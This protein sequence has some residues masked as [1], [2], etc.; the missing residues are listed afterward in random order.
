MTS[1]LDMLDRVVSSVEMATTRMYGERCGVAHALDLIGQRW[2]LLI[3]RELLLGPRRFTDLR[4]S[5][6]QASPD[7]LSRRLH[8]LEQTGVL[9]RHRLPPPAA[10]TVYEL[11]EWG[12]ELEPAVLALARWGTRSPHL[13]A[14]APLGADSVMLGLRTYFEPADARDDTGTYQLRLGEDTYVARIAGGQLHI[15]RGED[16]SAKAAISTDPATL[17]AV[18]NGSATIETVTRN[19]RASVTGDIAGMKWLLENVRIPQQARPS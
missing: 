7:M 10:S 14:D 19:G 16:P 18:F 12:R 6:S 9:R 15:G 11:T 1:K 3:V 8:E 4:R 5:V 13:P 17:A 2:A